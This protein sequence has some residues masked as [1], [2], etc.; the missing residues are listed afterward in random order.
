MTAIDKA[1]KYLESL[2]PGEHL[3]YQKVADQFGCSRSALSRRWRGVSRDKTTSDGMKQALLPQQE[4]ELVQYIEELHIRGLPPTRQMIQNF[5]SEICGNPV[6]MSWVERFLHRNQDRLISRWAPTL[7][8]VRHQ[9]DSIDKYDSYFDILHRKMEEHKIERRLT[10]NMDE[11]GFLIGVQNKSK[12]VF[13]KPVW[14]QDVA[15]AAIQDGNRDWITII[16]TI[17][18]DGTTLPTSIIMGKDTQINVSSSPT[19]W[20]NEKLG[21]AWLKRFDQFTKEKA[22]RSWRLLICDGHGSHLT[23]QF[24]DYAIENR[25]IVMV[26]PSHSTH[27]LQPLDVGVFGPLSHY[28]SSQLSQ[29]QQRSQGLLPVVKADFYGLF[30]PTY[31]SSFTEANIVAAFE[32][33]GIWPMDRTVVTKRFDYTTPPLQTDNISPSHLSPADWWRTERLVERAIKGNNDQVVTKLVG[34][35]HRASTQHKL[36]QYENKGLLASL[37]TKNKRTKRGRRLPLKGDQKRP[38]DAVF[39]SPRKLQ[40]ARDERARKDAKILANQARKADA[41]QLREAK[42]LLSEKSKQEAQE[43]RE[44]DKM[45]KEKENADKAARREQ[46]K[47]QEN[48]DKAIQPSQKGKRKA[49][50]PLPK[51]KKRQKR[52]DGS[53]ASGV[54]IEA[55]PAQPARTSRGGRN[56]KIPAKFR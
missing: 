11:K 24:L 37:D 33:T 50:R 2:K 17:C 39:Y 36:L 38:T 23:K 14:V 44:R 21:L 5:G 53:V 7:D 9:A 22:R 49:S 31:A 29:Q 16:P 15:R 34:A 1:V 13:S 27:T 51:Q 32:A 18:A 19:G 12:R 25:I 10:F 56:I 3:V 55:T 40:E 4:L 45:V 20:S 47:Q 48:S 42:K 30:K 8:R 52:V 43:K 28:Y 35:I 26:F 6:S 46:Q 41:K 54:A